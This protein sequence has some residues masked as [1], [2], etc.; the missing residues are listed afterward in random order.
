MIAFE[1]LRKRYGS[2]L[3]V[4]SVSFVAPDGMI[5]GLLGPNGAGKTTALRALAGL[6]KPDAGS[7]SIDGHDVRRDPRAARTRLGMLPEAAGL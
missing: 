7:A 2:T 6:V 5:T 1:N 4:D 3:A